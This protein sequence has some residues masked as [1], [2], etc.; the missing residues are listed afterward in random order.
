MDSKT[1]KYCQV[2]TRCAVFLSADSICL[3]SASCSSNMITF[4]EVTPTVLDNQLPMN[5]W[6]HPSLF[7]LLSDLLFYSSYGKCAISFLTIPSVLATRGSFLIALAMARCK[8]WPKK[9]ICN[10]SRMRQAHTKLLPL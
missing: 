6:G 8:L 7:V 2:G 10:Q 3:R 1:S 9:G 5:N 4:F